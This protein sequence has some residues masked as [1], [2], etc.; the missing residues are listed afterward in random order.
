MCGRFGSPYTSHDLAEA[1]AAEWRCDAPELPRYNVAPTQNAPVLLVHEGM[2]VLDVFRWGL[3]PSWAKEIS[4]GS[5]MIN[6][7]AETVLEK[8]SYRTAFQRRRCLVPAGGFYE[9]RKT[10]AGK[11]PQWIH[12]V[13]GGPLT[14]AGLWESWRPAK[15]AAP[16]HTFTILTTTPSADVAGIHD[17]MPVI[18][19]G[20]GRDAWLDAATPADDLAALLRPAPDGMLRA[21]AVSTAVNRPTYDGPDLLVP[22]EA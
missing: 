12:P 2:R 10:P 17:R 18:L 15:D 14:F 11:V 19:D 1:M 16:L 20:A 5:K 21:H 7:R 22:V 3:V 4:I 8:P 6:A 9:W 13:E